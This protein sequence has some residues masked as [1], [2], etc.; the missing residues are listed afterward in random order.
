MSKVGVLPARPARPLPPN[1]GSCIA[2]CPSAKA[3]NHEAFMIACSVRVAIHEGG[4][5]TRRL[6][7]MESLLLS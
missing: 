5:A 1:Y 2:H 3:W 4:V 7:L 6:T